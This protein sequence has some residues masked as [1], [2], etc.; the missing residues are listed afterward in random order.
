MKRGRDNLS[1]NDLL[2][3]SARKP[4]AMYVSKD[5]GV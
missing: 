5:Y 4:I 2:Q 1:V 3:G